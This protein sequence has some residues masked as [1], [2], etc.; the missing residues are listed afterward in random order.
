MNGHPNNYAT[1]A[2]CHSWL[3][4]AT[5]AYDVIQRLSDGETV[6]V[7]HHGCTH[8]YLMNHSGHIVEEVLHYYHGAMQ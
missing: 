6:H 4:L 8:T 3:N 2:Q 5:T 1:C 7:H